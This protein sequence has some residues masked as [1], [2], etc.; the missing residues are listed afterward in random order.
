MTQEQTYALQVMKEDLLNS[1]FFFKPSAV[2]WE[3]LSNAFEADLHNI[4]IGEVQS[5]NFN[6][7]FS[8]LDNNVL[9]THYFKCAMWM[10]YN[11]IKKRDT[12]FLLEKT[13]PLIPIGMNPEL[14]YNPASVHG[15]PGHYI[16]KN[17]TWDYLISLDTILKIAEVY[18]AI[19]TDPCTIADLGAGWGRIG[20]V[21][22]Q[23]NP[24]V[25]YNIFDI[26]H[27]LLISQEYLKD[28]LGNFKVYDY[29]EN[30]AVSSFSKE[31][32]IKFHLTKDLLKFESKSIDI[33]IN[34]ACFQEMSYAQIDSYFNIINEKAEYLYTQ[35]RYHDLAMEYKTYPYRSH[36]KKIF[37]NDITFLPLWFESM[38]KL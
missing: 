4:G 5:T 35:Q 1:E 27:T 15:R 20:Y 37:D 9:K 7:L 24:K 28:K 8:L 13:E 17:L 34:V 14:I 19:L 33:F 26:P 10:L 22:S 21:L 3:Q 29:L 38:F 30:R 2:L 25:S 18:P 31:A 11:D 23:I 6:T 12:Y 36:W 32:G 16:N